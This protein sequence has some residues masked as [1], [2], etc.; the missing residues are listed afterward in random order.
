MLLVVSVLYSM[1]N[2]IT[3]CPPSHSGSSRAMES[4]VLPA[5]MREGRLGA[6]G[7][8]G[9]CVCVCACVKVHLV[10]YDNSADP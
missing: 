10:K 6:G 8:A 5:L 4:H 3:V 1:S 7:L 9:V 2:A